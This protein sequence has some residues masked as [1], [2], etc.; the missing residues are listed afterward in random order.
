MKISVVM[1]LYNTP[2]SYLKATVESLLSQ[3]FKDS[4]LII[5]DDASTVEY[6]EFFKQFNDDRIKYIKL[7]KNSGPGAA[8]NTGIRQAQGEYIAIADSDDIYMPQRLELQAKFLDENPEISLIG[9]AFRP[10][11]KK[12]ISAV[13]ENDKEIKNFMLFN[14][15]L[16][17]PTIMFRKKAFADKNLFYPEDINFAEDY[18][19]WIN[20]MFSGVKI[21]NLKDFLMIYTRRA[22][23]LSK[24]K[25]E[26]QITILKNIYKKMFSQLGL[27]A[28][29]EELDLHYNIY[30]EK[31]KGVK[32][33]KQISDWFDKII[34]H[35][36]KKKIFDEKLLENKKNQVLEKYNKVSSRF[37][38]LK[39]GQKN[40]CLDKNFKMY[41]EQRS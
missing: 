40:L 32:S 30:S 28:T 5:V 19:L 29:D 17:N 18:Q 12:K 39:I 20:A 1:A 38:K 7:E 14:S 10:S 23:Q 37:F 31:F 27:E 25:N 2:C 6:E 11:N 24:E 33:A 3:T 21:A 8:R 16:N 26:I 34:E 13:L 15:P 35:N 9:T 41:L 36:R 22:G 4:E